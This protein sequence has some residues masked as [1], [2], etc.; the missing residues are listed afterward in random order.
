MTGV[1]PLA[2]R[3]I[4]GPANFITD[5]SFHPDL[6]TVC[7]LPPASVQAEVARIVSQRPELE[8]DPRAAEDLFQFMQDY[9]NGYRF[10]ATEQTTLFIPQ[11]CLKFF[12][13]LVEPSIP[14][15]NV[16]ETIR[17]ARRDGTYLLRKM[18]SLAGGIDVNSQVHHGMRVA[19]ILFLLLTCS[20]THTHTHTH[21][22]AHTRTRTH[23]H[24]HAHTHTHLVPRF[25]LLPT[26]CCR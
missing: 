19:C 22:H 24:T 12:Q 13:F 26:T 2:I 10:V 9:F 14:I 23:T 16:L 21:T 18:G 1:T 4:S 11:Q 7:G 3:E 15:G 17:S 5:V 20:H 6:A 8:G 25:H